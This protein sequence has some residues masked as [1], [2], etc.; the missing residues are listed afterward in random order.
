[1]SKSTS[2]FW[3]LKLHRLGKNEW[4]YFIYYVPEVP[5]ALNSHLRHYLTVGNL[6]VFAFIARRAV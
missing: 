4:D 6:Y 5:S 2:T 3:K 1:M